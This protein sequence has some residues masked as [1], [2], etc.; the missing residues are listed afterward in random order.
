MKNS[1]ALRMWFVIHFFVDYLA[2]IPLFIFPFQSLSFLGWHTIDPLATRIIASALFAIGGVSLIA[3]N[4]TPE[5]YREIL[6]LKI[7][8]SFFVTTA[9][10]IA[11]MQG[12][13]TWGILVSIILFVFFGLVWAYYRL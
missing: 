1:Q 10:V 2:A 7:I 4:A 3:R 5:V 13:I 12:E 6:T 8:W 11:L 9:L